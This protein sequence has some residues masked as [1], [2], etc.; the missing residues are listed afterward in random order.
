MKKPAYRNISDEINVM[1]FTNTGIRLLGYYNREKQEF[2]FLANG[3]ADT[4]VL[5][6][7]N[8][9]LNRYEFSFQGPHISYAKNYNDLV[10]SVNKKVPAAEGIDAYVELTLDLNPMNSFLQESEFVIIGS[11]GHIVYSGIEEGKELLGERKE[12][13]SLGDYFFTRAE[14]EDGYRVFI[15]VPRKEYYQ[16]FR[17]MLPAAFFAVLCFGA[18]FSVVVFL[19]MKNVVRPLHVFEEE[20]CK[21]QQGDLENRSYQ[22]TLIPEYDHLLDEVMIMKQ[23]IQGLL[24]EREAAQRVQAKARVDQLLYKI[25]PHFL[26]NSLDTIHWLAVAENT[27]EIDKVARALNKLLYYNLKVDRNTVRLEEEIQAVRQYVLLQQSRFTFQFA[28]DIQDEKALQARIPRFILQPLVENAIYHG[29]RENGHLVLMADVEEKLNIYVKDDGEGMEPQMLDELQEEA[30]RG[31]KEGNKL[32]I[33][34]NYVI[35]I[36][37][38]QFGE[39]VTIQ[40]MSR[41]QEGTIIHISMPFEE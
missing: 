11:D 5:P 36:L 18:V 25:N 7:N 22:K 35:Q 3:A 27:K 28:V 6:E 17:K 39:N 33:G 12:K 13:G 2:V 21:I 26:M 14:G 10:I 24:E 34:L 40:V 15:L 32:G 8:Y 30:R 37:R 16:L 20:I 4:H 1:S 29:L 38:E 31:K 19:M 9:L 41:K 23:R